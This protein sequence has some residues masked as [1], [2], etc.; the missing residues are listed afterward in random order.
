MK[1]IG[2]R[3]GKIGVDGIIII[4]IEFS[5]LITGPMGAYQTLSAFAGAAEFGLLA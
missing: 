2:K 1:Q 3:N 4:P 5:I